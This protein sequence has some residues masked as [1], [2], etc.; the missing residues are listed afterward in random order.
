LGLF[1][2]TLQQILNMPVPVPAWMD[3]DGD[4][5]I[6]FDDAR[7]AFKKE[8]DSFIDFA[9]R[10]NVLEVAV[11]LMCVYSTQPVQH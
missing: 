4:G 6:D 9:L 3:A 11:G 10:D 1:T 8:W 5:N 7:T 2:P